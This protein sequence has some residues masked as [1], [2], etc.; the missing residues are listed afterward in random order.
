MTT[1]AQTASQTLAQFAA[2]LILED[3]PAPVRERAKD[4]LIDSVGVGSF[5]ARF[6][7]SRAVVEHAK[8]YGAGGPCS[9]LGHPGLRLSAPFAALANGSLIHAFEQDNLRQ[10]GVGVHAGATIVPALLAAAEETGADGGPRTVS[11]RF[12]PPAHRTW[13]QLVGL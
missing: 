8:S 10:P 11:L 7:W 3:I 1:A 2:G 13:W 4:C 5:G 6:P 9:V 12:Y